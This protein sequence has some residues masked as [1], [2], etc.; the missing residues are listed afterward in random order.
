MTRQVS[1]Q[2]STQYLRTVINSN[3]ISTRPTKMSA[4]ASTQSS[5]MFLH[6]VIRNTIIML[7]LSIFWPYEQRA[8]FT[9]IV[10]MSHGPQ[11]PQHTNRT[12][13]AATLN[14]LT[15]VSVRTTMGST[16]RPHGTQRPHNTQRSHRSMRTH[17]THRMHITLR[18]NGTQR[19]EKT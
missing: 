3:N 2:A 15:A 11:S 14:T 8:E 9:H 12:Q 16:Q 13:R 5:I 10:L 19:P 1:T 6:K 17:T 7:E 18:P 4:K